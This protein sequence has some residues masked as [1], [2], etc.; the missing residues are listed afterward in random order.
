MELFDRTLRELG[1]GLDD[2][3]NLDK[4]GLALGVCTNS[5]VLASSRKKRAYNKMPGNRE[6]VSILECI[7]ATGSKTRPL[8]IFKG[9]HAQTTWFQD[10]E[11]QDWI[12]T[13][14]E[15]GWTSDKIS[16]HWLEAI[17]IPETR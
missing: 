6:W 11:I 2:I 14:S 5:Q 12:Y 1:V 7:S 15:N 8:V 4:T 10:N 3:Y 17:F 16:L 9:K 13:T